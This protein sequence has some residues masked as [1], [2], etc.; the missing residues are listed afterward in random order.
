MLEIN[1][2]DFRFRR[3]N[4]DILLGYNVITNK[5]FFF[6][7]NTKKYIEAKL[8]HEDTIFL[9]DKYMKYLLNNKILIEGD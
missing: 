3:E 9:E 2:K 6:K 7:G 5:M 4:D 8:N 1:Q